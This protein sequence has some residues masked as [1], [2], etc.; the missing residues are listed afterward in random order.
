MRAR[1]I[2]YVTYHAATRCS[3][4]APQ[5][6]IVTT[7][8]G[9]PTEIHALVAWRVEVLATQCPIELLTIVWLYINM[10]KIWRTTIHHG[11]P[12]WNR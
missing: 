2:D 8:E 7:F 4:S 11:V 5:A 10:R 6:L 9:L 3:G 1:T 12:L